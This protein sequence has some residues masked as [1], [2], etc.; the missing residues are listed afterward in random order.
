MSYHDEFLI[1]EKEIGNVVEIAEKIAMWKMPI[2]IEKD[3][4]TLYEY[5]KSQN[6]T[7]HIGIPYTRYVKINWQEQMN[8]SLWQIIMD[9]FK[10]QWDLRIGI[11]TKLH[12][13][14]NDTIQSR[15]IPKQKYLETI[16]YGPYQKL[17]TTYKSLYYYA[18]EHNIEL[19]SSSFEFYQNNPKEVKPHEL[20]TTVLVAIRE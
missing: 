12:V 9:M 13:D 6:Q 10:Y 18:K 11:P 15:T 2:T 3:L 16:H 19:E 14:G 1:V 5:L 8:K 20:Q 17:G 4:T 7:E